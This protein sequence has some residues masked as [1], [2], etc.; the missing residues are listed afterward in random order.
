MCQ[1]DSKDG[2]RHVVLL[3]I[4]GSCRLAPYCSVMLTFTVTFPPQHYLPIRLPAADLYTRSYTDKFR[5]L[6][7]ALSPFSLPTVRGRSQVDRISNT[8]YRYIDVF[9]DATY[10]FILHMKKYSTVHLSLKDR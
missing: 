7:R 6:Y 5:D 4:A 10:I 2:T 3:W 8:G 1:R 9:D